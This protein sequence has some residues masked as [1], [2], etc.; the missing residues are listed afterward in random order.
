M[1]APPDTHTQSVQ[2]INVLL[3]D[4]DEDDFLITNHL[5]AEIK[6]VNFTLDW[7]SDYAEALEKIG[8]G[9]YDV[10]LIDYRLGMHS[11]IELVNRAVE[12]GNRLPYIVLTGQDNESTDMSA[13]KAGATD[14]LI[15][16]KLD[17]Y[18]LERAIRYAL[19]RNR[20]NEV[21]YEKDRRARTLFENSS[22]GIFITD[23]NDYFLEVNMA[24]CNL[25]KAEKESLMKLQLP[26]LFALRDDYRVFREYRAGLAASGS[27]GTKEVELRAMNG[28]KINC[29]I[30]TD[31]LTDS[32]GKIK[33]FQGIVHDI[34]QRKKAER[35]LLFAEK[36]GMTGRIA[37]SIA[38]E[39]RN[40]LTNVILSVEQLKLELPPDED[41]NFFIDIISNNCRRINTL[42]TELLESSKP[43]ELNLMPND[44]K[45]AVDSALLLAADRIKLLNITLIKDFEADIPPFPFD[46][47]KLRTA[48]LNIIINAI[49]AMPV[50]GGRLKIAINR[51]KNFVLV[52]IEDNGLGIPKENIGKLFDAFFTGKKAGMGLG[53]TT[54]QNIISTHKGTIEIES[55]VGSGT[56][57]IISFNLNNLLTESV[58]PFELG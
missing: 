38:H 16:S 17:S 47:L 8:S 25:F 51:R 39:V 3:V 46:L 18:I 44:I 7:V 50:T 56:R 29:I 52:T 4:D 22:D 1:Q 53:L 48:F 33:G 5:L 26:D 23:F 15:K 6:R 19:E 35:E 2:Q 28:D 57:F 13:F 41:Y 58:H 9:R 49:E 27:G 31:F 34:T 43:A 11:G 37:R 55:E 20:I 45:S 14:Y 21:L 36:L 12:L 40:P 32:S 30:T 10:F 24:G 54:A 42:I